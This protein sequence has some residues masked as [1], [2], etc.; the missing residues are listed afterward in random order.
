M[1]DTCVY[2]LEM[3]TMGFV[4]KQVIPSKQLRDVHLFEL[5]K[6]METPWI[7]SHKHT[8]NLA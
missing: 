7:S 6:K 3:M 4:T 2:Q 8:H 1:C 5:T